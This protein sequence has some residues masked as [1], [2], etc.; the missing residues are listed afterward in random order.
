MLDIELNVNL[1]NII[2]DLDD[3]V[4]RQ[5]PYAAYLALNETVFKAS[6]DVRNKVF[7]AKYIEGGP[8]PFTK[9][10]VQYRKAKS[11]RELIAWI[12]IPDNQWKYMQY[13]I[14]GGIKKWGRSRHGIGVPIY[15][16]V[17]FNKYGNIPGRKRKEALWREVLNRG[18]GRTAVPM[19]GQ[20]PKNQFIGK[21]AGG[22]IGLWRRRGQGG[23]AKPEL[24]VYFTREGVPY[25]KTVPFAL[26]A[27]YYGG[28]RFR[29]AFNKKLRQ[30]VNRERS[31][32]KVK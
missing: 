7:T 16:N 2:D 13:V 9:R 6:M 3:T 31:A 28:I 17:R 4:K 8:V 24:L 5:V 1:D 32:V 27:G 18:G 30:V 12:F 29:G 15:E 11:K 25:K 21:S 26:K 22:I 10:G 14:E 20:L 19:R 23:R